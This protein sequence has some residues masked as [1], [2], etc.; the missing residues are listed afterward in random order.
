MSLI[1]EFEIKHVL[2]GNMLYALLV[3]KFLDQQYPL[4]SSFCQFTYQAVHTSFADH[5][6]NDSMKKRS[7]RLNKLIFGKS[8]KCT[9]ILRIMEV[10]ISFNLTL[11]ATVYRKD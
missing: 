9:E 11:I 6:H 7:V 2:N 4:N 10:L 1:A 5:M 8:V 3:I